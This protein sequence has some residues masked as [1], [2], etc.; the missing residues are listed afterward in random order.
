M[1]Y[2]DSA[3][4]HFNHNVA[5]TPPY[6]SE[7]MFVHTHAYIYVGIHLKLATVVEGDKKAPF[8]YN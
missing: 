4:Q 5:R 2:S 3:V 1:S 7:F 8:F 6:M